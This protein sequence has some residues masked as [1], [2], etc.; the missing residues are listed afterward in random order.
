MTNTQWILFSSM[1]VVIILAA[2]SSF[3]LKRRIK[4]IKE[5]YLAQDREQ[6]YLMLQKLRNDLGELPFNLKDELKNNYKPYDIEAVINTIFVN[7]FDSTLIIDNKDVFLQSVVSSKT[8]R[9]IYY[10]K[11]YNFYSKYLELIEKYPNELDQS[12]LIE[13]DGQNLNFIA[14]FN[15]TYKLED[16]FNQFFPALQ[17]E[18]MM[19][20][21][22]S[23]YHKKELIKF[24]KLIKQS[25]LTY[26]I[27]Y[28][29]SK[30]LY[31]V[32]R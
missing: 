24:I 27:S 13:Y 1:I 16:L 15:N 21:L 7:D 12:N 20:I 23:N 19:M 29:E 22:T 25:N 10:L 2:V 9:K 14:V 17:P 4:K 18:S 3:L 31:I 28:V 8:K 26:E 32:K 5:K 6:T 11:E 30:F